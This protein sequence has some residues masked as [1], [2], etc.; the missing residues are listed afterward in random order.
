MPSSTVPRCGSRDGR[1]LSAR[2]R[3]HR[4]SS[5]GT[6]TVL[7]VDGRSLMRECLARAL[8]AEWPAAARDHRLARSRPVRGRQS[9]STLRRLARRHW[10]LAVTRR[11]GGRHRRCGAGRAVS[12]DGAMPASAAAARGARG[13]FSTSV[14]LRVL[15]QGLRLVLLGGTAMPIAGS[16]TE[17]RRNRSGRRHRVRSRASRPSCSRPRN[18]RC[19]AAS[20][21]AGR[22]S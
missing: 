19:C 22:T 4:Q 9:A 10:R 2:A 7:L 5:D 11:D 13:Y 6:A 20:P 17:R 15:V 18:W 16:G 21:T 3:P 12:D 14:D 1:E 8:G